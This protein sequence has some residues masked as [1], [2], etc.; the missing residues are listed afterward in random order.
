MDKRI[1]TTLNDF[2]I[3]IQNDR[4]ILR[5]VTDIEQNSFG[6]NIT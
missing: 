4:E 2:K 6:C 5:P 3:E 1:Q